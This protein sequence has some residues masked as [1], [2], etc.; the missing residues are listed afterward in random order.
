MFCRFRL[1]GDQGTEEFTFDVLNTLHECCAGNAWQGD[2]GSVRKP[3]MKPYFSAG[4][5]IQ[6][7]GHR[8]D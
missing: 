4:P 1:D 6:L 7:P 2:S 3:G 5:E 8:E